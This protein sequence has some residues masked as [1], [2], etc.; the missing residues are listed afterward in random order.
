MK[1]SIRV[2]RP[3]NVEVDILDLCH[4]ECDSFGACGLVLSSCQS[5]Y[6]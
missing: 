6:H 1:N 3:C 4:F 5:V 2:G